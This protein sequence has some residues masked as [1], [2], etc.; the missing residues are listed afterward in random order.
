MNSEETMIYIP[1]QIMHII[2]TALTFEDG[3]SMHEYVNK[4]T[5]D[6]QGLIDRNELKHQD[7][8]KPLKA[9]RA[10]IKQGKDEFKKR[11]LEKLAVDVLPDEY[12]LAVKHFACSE[13]SQSDQ[14]KSEKTAE[15]RKNIR[16]SGAAA[17]ATI[18]QLIKNGKEH[19]DAEL[20]KLALLMTSGRRENEVN[21][22]ITRR[23]SKDNI[24][25]PSSSPVDFNKVGAHLILHSN[26]G[27]NEDC[28]DTI[29][30]VVII[31]AQEWLD[32]YELMYSLRNEM[33]RSY[34]RSAGPCL[35]GIRPSEEGGRNVFFYDKTFRSDFKLD[36]ICKGWKLDQ[37][38]RIWSVLVQQYFYFCPDTTSAY[39][40]RNASLGHKALNLSY[41]QTSSIAGF[42]IK[43]AKIELY[44]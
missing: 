26:Q 39:L 19:R 3:H 43:K 31:T 7:S 27:K 17:E 15:T 32:L 42:E 11:L 37:N 5:D 44:C 20:L 24:T 12:A 6:L 8:D 16:V 14:E 21:P 10:K 18:R 36:E 2:E 4:A 9:P 38:R 30:P 33:H 13:L 23:N 34:D 28:H 35:R 41:E 22:L 25:C 40:L 1:T 29:F